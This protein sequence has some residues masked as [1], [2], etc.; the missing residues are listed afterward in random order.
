VYFLQINQSHCRTLVTAL[1]G[2]NIK[3]YL[4]FTFVPNNFI[5]FLGVIAFQ[6]LKMNIITGKNFRKLHVQISPF[7]LK[8]TLS[9]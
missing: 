7:N 2:L 4:T 3:F 8:N 9:T 5:S 1:V 6:R